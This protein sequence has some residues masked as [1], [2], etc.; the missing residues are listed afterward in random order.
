MPSLASVSGRRRNSTSTTRFDRPIIAARS[1][2]IS[3]C[4][5]MRNWIASIG[6]GG[7]TGSGD[8]PRSSRTRPLDLDFPM[9]GET[10]SEIEIDEALAGHASLG[11]HALE[12]LDH[13]LREAHGHR[14]RPQCSRTTQPQQAELWRP[15]G[16]AP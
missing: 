9:L 3:P 12:I 14:F 7:S 10:V 2:G 4:C 15:L 1:L 6:T 8:C 13:I 11:G 5:S 16:A